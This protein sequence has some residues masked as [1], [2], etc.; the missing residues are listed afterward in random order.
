MDRPI[1]NI[2]LSQ[3]SSVNIV[4]FAVGILAQTAHLLV[5]RCDD[6]RRNRLR[7]D[8]GGFNNGRL[9]GGSEQSVDGRFEVRRDDWRGGRRGIVRRGQCS[10][11]WIF[12]SDGRSLSILSV[13]PAHHNQ[14]REAHDR[15]DTRSLINRPTQRVEFPSTHHRPPT[16]KRLLLRL[17]LTTR[18]STRRLVPPILISLSQFDQRTSLLRIFDESML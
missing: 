18:T 3:K 4:S 6:Q 9:S 13:S 15:T 14:T 17:L 10:Q 2:S 8:D 11:F 7:I 5:D 16:T 1:P 12:W